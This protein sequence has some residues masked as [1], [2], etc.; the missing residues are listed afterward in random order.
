LSSATAL[1]D[2]ETPLRGVV[3][4][5]DG[6][7]TESALDFGLIRRECGLAVGEPILEY[8]ESAPAPE[9]LRVQ[10]VLER[11][12]ARA[13]RRCALREGA[14]EVI[15]ELRRRGVRTALLTRNS[16]RSVRTVVRRFGLQFDC[17]VS[18]DDGAP[19]P[20]PEPVLR[21]ASRLGLRPSE[22]LVVG[23]YVFDVQAGRAA[24]ATTALLKVR[25]GP[26][27]PPDPHIVL[28]H[29]S[30]LLD[31]FPEGQRGTE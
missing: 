11:H 2:R 29:L 7:L 1:T 26:P 31:L 8:M 13:A 9:R 30:E 16:A 17:C 20:S 15:D 22:L 14:R 6:T 5:M 10:V 24:G 28:H 23:D 25:K 12:E 27:P 4:D 18:R 21:I 19:K 3:L